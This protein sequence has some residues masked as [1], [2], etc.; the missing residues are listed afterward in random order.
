MPDNY[1]IVKMSP[2]GRCKRTVIG[3][4]AVSGVRACFNNRISSFAVSNTHNIHNTVS[5]MSGSRNSGKGVRVCVCVCGGGSLCVWGGGGRFTDF[6]YFFLN[7]KLF[8]LHRIFKK[9]GGGG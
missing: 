4:Q 5:I 6:T 7:I 8:H 9:K 1:V 3:R 2:S